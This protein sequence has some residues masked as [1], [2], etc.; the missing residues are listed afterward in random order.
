MPARVSS[1]CAR[2]A[3]GPMRTS[4]RAGSP[5]RTSPSRSDLCNAQDQELAEA[6]A[7]VTR[8]VEEIAALTHEHKSRVLFLL[9]PDINDYPHTGSY[10]Y[11]K[12]ISFYPFFRNLMRE[13]GYDY[14]D[15]ANIVGASA[16]SLKN[17]LL[18]DPD[19]YTP[20]GH[21]IIAHALRDHLKANYLQN[22]NPATE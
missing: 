21:R 20:E 5:T 2:V 22:P 18:L 19:H 15:V 1:S 12:L 4:R 14:L 6:E 16:A 17:D 11:R 3:T 9:L 10:H 13:K 7:T 8:L